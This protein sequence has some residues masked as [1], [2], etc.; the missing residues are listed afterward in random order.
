MRHVEREVLANC[1]EKDL[2]DEFKR[3]W[4]SVWRAIRIDGKTQRPVESREHGQDHHDIESHVDDSLE[5][6]LVPGCPVLVPRP[7]LVK[8]LVAL[9]EFELEV[10]AEVV[11]QAR[12]VVEDLELAA[13]PD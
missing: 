2:Q 11:E 3:T 12:Q 1:A 7:W 10:I 6:Q 5:E 8:G 9:E 4:H 13:A